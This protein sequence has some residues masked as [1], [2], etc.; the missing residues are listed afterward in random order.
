MMV[1]M[2]PETPAHRVSCR[3]GPQDAEVPGPVWLGQGREPDWGRSLPGQPRLSRGAM[4]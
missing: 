1:K 4:A 3:P 2:G